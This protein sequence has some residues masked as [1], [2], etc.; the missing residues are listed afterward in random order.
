MKDI[1]IIGGGVI[2]CLIAREIAKYD[3]EICVI[4]K[5]SDVASET[6]KANSS[7]VHGG[8]DAPVGSN[9]AK[10]NVKGNKMMKKTCEQLNVHY[11]NNGSIVLAFN[12][13]QVETLKEI[14]ER[15]IKNGVG[16]LSIISG[17]EVRE[18]EPSISKEAKAAI[19]AKTG[20]IVCPYKL[21]HNA[22]QNAAE[23]GVQFIFNCKLIEIENKG[24][25]F[26]L[27]TTKGNIETKYIINAAGVFA[28]EVARMAGDNTFSIYPRKGEYILF[29]KKLGK[30]V[31]HT[32]FQ[33]PTKLGKGILVTPT[34]D[35]NLL[36]G[37]TAL[38]IENKNDYDTTREVLLEVLEGAKKSVPSISSKN[39]I[40]SFS[41]LRAIADKD[42]FIIGISEKVE[43]LINVAGIQSPG[44][45]ASPA[46]AEYVAQLLNDINHGKLPLKADYNPTIEVKPEIISI[47]TEE[48][49]ELVNKNPAY[50]K[51]VCRCETVSEGEIVDSIKCE[52]GATTIDGVKRR[53][54]AGMGRCQGGFCMPRVLEILSRELG[55]PFTK[56]QKNDE[57][58][59]ILQ[60]ET[61]GG[62]A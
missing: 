36:I 23:N 46:I 11:K 56:I 39:I 58:T 14:Y 59:F 57:G 27:I 10:F 8:F 51:I 54:R 45:S 35:G 4:E 38:N 25:Y 6:S 17:E 43:R 3:I 55:I 2:G 28:D 34:V 7:I 24:D 29:D 62:I 13:E 16:G 15:G 52:C 42:D 19:L 1:T 31:N 53:T 37:P 12:D 30:E 50:G 44:L 47:T 32:I 21:T 5:H 49:A 33:T 48:L 9:K 41:G 26:N 60:S 61:K 20:G 40:T 22:A 18:I